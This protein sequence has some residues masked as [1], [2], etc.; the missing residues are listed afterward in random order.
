MR[1]L[2]CVLQLACFRER[3][4]YKEDVMGKLSEREL[5]KLIQGGETNTSELLEMANDRGL[6]DW[7][8]LPARH[9]TMEDINLEKVK[10]YLSQA[11]H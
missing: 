1:N 5:K 11:H 8:H 10:G 6:V 7:E 4:E 3:Q 9:A 2:L